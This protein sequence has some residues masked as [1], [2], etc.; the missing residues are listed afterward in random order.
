M[1]VFYFQGTRVLILFLLMKGNTKMLVDYLLSSL[2][3]FVI[4]GIGQALSWVVEYP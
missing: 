1:K 2:V 4:D 3:C